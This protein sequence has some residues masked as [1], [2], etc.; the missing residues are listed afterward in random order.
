MGI[1]KVTIPKRENIMTHQN[2]YSFA[3]DIAE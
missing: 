1:L 3:Y 2:H